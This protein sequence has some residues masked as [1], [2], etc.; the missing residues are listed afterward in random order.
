MKENLQAQ[1]ILAPIPAVMVS[2]GNMENANILTIAWTGIINSEPPYCYVSIRP[3]R[4]SYDIIKENKE[5]VLNLPNESLVWATDFCG[6]KT[7]KEVDKFKEAK[8]TKQESK[9]VKAPSIK[10]C[11]ISIECK[12]KEIKPLG[13]HHMFIGE[14]VNISAEQDLIQNGKIDFN[15]AGLI[16]YMGNKYYV[17]NKEVGERGICLH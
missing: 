15:K 5:F 16:T 8:L 9:I 17:V 4:Y 13:S 12:L 11:P 14:I 1:T 3:E 10:E 2:C 6:T 7:G